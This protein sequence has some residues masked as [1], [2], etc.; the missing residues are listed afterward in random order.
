[1]IYKLTLIYMLLISLGACSKSKVDV[2]SPSKSTLEIKAAD[3]SF[4]PEIRK[5]GITTR[6]RNGQIEDMLMTLKN[7]GCNTIRLRLWHTPDDEHSGFNEVKTFSQEIK[8]L[9]MKVMLT[10]HYSDY[11]ADPGT[12]TKP[13]AWKTLNFTQLKDSVYQYTSRIVG[14]I[15]PDL[16]Q[17]GNEINNGLLWPDGNISKPDQMKGLITSGVRAVRDKDPAI[18]IMIHYAGHEEALTFF[19]K[20]KDIDFDIIGLSYYPMWHGRDMDKLKTNMEKVSSTF[21][22]GLLIAETSYP[23]TFDFNDKTNNI[24]GTEN[25]ILPQYPPSP[26]GQLDFL[27]ALKTI[28]STNPKGLG[29]AY[30]APE[31]V[32]FKGVDATDGS[33]YENQALWG[34]D[35]KALPG[36]KVFNE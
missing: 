25:Q 11:W 15:K 21:N 14:E 27:M 13:K 24:I 35:N 23:F 3:I 7:E 32:A 33:P 17:I 10:V 34:F 29:F 5:S 4:L 18:K 6:N 12:Q 30:W 2:G 26:K 19:D 36:I 16:I 28:I 20:L 1:M 8:K 9:G 31:W 22:K